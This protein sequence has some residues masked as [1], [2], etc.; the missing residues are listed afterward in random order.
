ME[1]WTVLFLA[2]TA[3]VCLHKQSKAVEENRTREI[4]SE[5]AQQLPF[6]HH[7][8]AYKQG[9]IASNL[10]PFFSAATVQREIEKLPKVFGNDFFLYV[11]QKTETRK[12]RRGER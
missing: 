7:N 6:S 3:T 4:S 10:K 9:T 11:H 1:V 2:K 12:E 5:R 8:F